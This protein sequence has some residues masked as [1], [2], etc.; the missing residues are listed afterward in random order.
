MYFRECRVQIMESFESFRSIY[1]KYKNC[2]IVIITCKI[3]WLIDE[4]NRFIRTALLYVG[5]ILKL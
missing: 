4:K 3:S 5:Y 1:S 2:V